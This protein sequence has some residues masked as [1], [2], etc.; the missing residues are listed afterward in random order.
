[1][2]LIWWIDG[3]VLLLLGFLL[4]VQVNR[5]HW[6]QQR[7][8]ALELAWGQLV[9]DRLRSDHTLHDVQRELAELLLAA[10]RLKQREQEISEYLWR[11]HEWLASEQEGRYRECVAP[12]AGYHETFTVKEMT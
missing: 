9:D 10:G 11:L 2:S 4:V 8:L 1:M 5:L 6:H 3:I 7:L 12:L